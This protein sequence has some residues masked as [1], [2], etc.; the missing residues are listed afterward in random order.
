MYYD[1]QYINL[2]DLI[3][4]SGSYIIKEMY[5]KAKEIYRKKLLS[6]DTSK[7]VDFAALDNSFKIDFNLKEKLPVTEYD[8]ESPYSKEVLEKQAIWK[9]AISK[10]ENE[11]LSIFLKF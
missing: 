11:I 3:R 4:V 1:S 8:L 6:R 9:D 10:Y 5:E 2:I 7:K